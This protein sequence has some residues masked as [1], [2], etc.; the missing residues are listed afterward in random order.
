MRDLSI[1]FP[2]DGDFPPDA[3]EQLLSILNQY[4]DGHQED[5]HKRYCVGRFVRA[6]NSVVFRYRACSE[7]NDQYIRLWDQLGNPEMSPAEPR[8]F[9]ERD[10]F[11]F[12]VNALSCVEA[13]FMAFY[14]MTATQHPPKP[15]P[16]LPDRPPKF[17]PFTLTT[18]AESVQGVFDSFEAAY[19]LDPFT[20]GL[21]R[22]KNDPERARLEEQRNAI[23]HGSGSFGRDVY[24]GGPGWGY[25]RIS[26]EAL[27]EVRIW[28]SRDLGGLFPS[29]VTFA[30][31]ILL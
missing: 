13:A 10:L 21:Y 4:R 25:F 7:S 8:Y 18:W 26:R 19:P 27:E 5:N 1:G 2:I 11:N 23:A 16:P 22:A 9:Q 12:I 24:S 14:A 31:Q 15:P 28:L 30:Q 29:A 3:W 6:W 20:L 17:V